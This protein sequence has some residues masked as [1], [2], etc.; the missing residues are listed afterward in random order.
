M[1]QRFRCI[2]YNTWD[3][4]NSP[5]KGL[6]VTSKAQRQ[7]KPKR[8]TQPHNNQDPQI[9]QRYSKFYNTPSACEIRI[10]SISNLNKRKE[11]KVK[12]TCQSIYIYIYIKAEDVVI[13][14]PF[15][16]YGNVFCMTLG[17]LVG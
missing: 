2:T 1:K 15:G 8:Q 3:P 6:P 16:M 9:K 7:S 17:N 11:K 5:M 10:T 4:I 13:Y 14:L 12:P